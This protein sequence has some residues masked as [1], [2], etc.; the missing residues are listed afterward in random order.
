MQNSSS[1][2]QPG[3]HHLLLLNKIAIARPT[4]GVTTKPPTVKVTEDAILAGATV[5]LPLIADRLSAS[6]VIRR[7]T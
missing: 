6:A 2:K 3:S 1:P 4:D 5:I 7:A